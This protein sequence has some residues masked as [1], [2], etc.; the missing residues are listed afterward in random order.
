M[1]VEHGYVFGRET[2]EVAPDREPEDKLQPYQEKWLNQGKEETPEELEAARRRAMEFVRR[3]I[4]KRAQS[5]EYLRRMQGNEKTYDPI[6]GRY[7]SD[8]HLE[9]LHDSVVYGDDE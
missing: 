7:H 3:K 8:A 2:P 5:V 9:D 4:H 1:A 6:G